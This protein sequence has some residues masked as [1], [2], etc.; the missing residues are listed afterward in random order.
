MLKKLIPDDYYKTIED[1]P[2]SKLY[3]DGIRLILTDLDNTL[4]SYLE[5]E[6]TE[7][8]FVWKNKIKE[9]GFEIIV[10]SN[11]RKDRVEHFANLLDVPFIKFAKKPLLFG[12]RKAVKL[13]SREYKKEEIV[14]IGDQ[15]MT[16]VFAS[17]RFGVH[18]ILV[19]AID[20]KTEIFPTK[21]N[22]KLEKFFLT[23]IERR[24][25]RLYQQ[26]LDQYVV[27]KDE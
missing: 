9:M 8:L 1:I 24:H 16:D 6:P 22:R 14:E 17:K 19:K 15:L 18:T 11:S 12:M 26:H 20:K 13:A 5:N 3:A 7:A 4:I 23:Q 10:V 2:Y 21:I 25:P 27:D